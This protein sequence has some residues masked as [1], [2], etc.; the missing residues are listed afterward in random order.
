M[1]T[2]TINTYEFAELSAEAQQ[3]IINDHI[4]FEITIMDEHSP[5]WYLALKMEKMQTPWFLGECIYESH[6]ADIIEN[7]KLNE[8]MFT[9]AGNIA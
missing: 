5:Y 1:K 6:L 3:K 7:I 9:A 4:N 2:K 8:Y